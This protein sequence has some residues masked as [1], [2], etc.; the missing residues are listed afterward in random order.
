MEQL[1]TDGF[2]QSAPFIWE[3]SD[4]SSYWRG[5]VLQFWR[6]LPN[7][8]WL[9]C[10]SENPQLSFWDLSEAHKATCGGLSVRERMHG[11]TYTLN[12]DTLSIV[13][14]SVMVEPSIYAWTIRSPALIPYNSGLPGHVEL[15]FNA[16]PGSKN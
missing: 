13:Q 5:P 11:G 14:L 15:W 7:N 3:E 9:R 16:A 1:R 6:F 4:G 2:Y 12:N 10:I 8:R